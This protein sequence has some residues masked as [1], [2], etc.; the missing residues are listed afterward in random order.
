MFKTAVGRLAQDAHIHVNKNRNAD[1][2]M[3]LP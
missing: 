2:I 1:L 3:L